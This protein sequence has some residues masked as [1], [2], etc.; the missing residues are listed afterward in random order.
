LGGTIL[1]FLLLRAILGMAFTPHPTLTPNLPN[2]VDTMTTLHF[3]PQSLKNFQQYFAQIFIQI[4]TFNVI[5]LFLFKSCS[6]FSY[7][8]L[9]FCFSAIVEW[10]LF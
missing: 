2:Q 9:N 5:F 1:N 10:L 6:I 4:L 8:S 7:L 3:N